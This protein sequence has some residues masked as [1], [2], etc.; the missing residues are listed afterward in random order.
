M[1]RPTADAACMSD[2]IQRLRADKLGSQDTAHKN[3]FTDGQQWAVEVAGYDQL[4]RLAAWADEEN[5]MDIF[6]NPY[7]PD[8][9]AMALYLAVEG[10]EPPDLEQDNGD[11]FWER[12][13]S[14]GA[15]SVLTS[16]YVHGFA[17]GALDVFGAVRDQI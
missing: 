16:G 12:A 2:V 7:E 10:K 3:G 15:A 11:G 14:V 13:A 6:Y 4:V 8:W 17:E 9:P 5:W 1:N